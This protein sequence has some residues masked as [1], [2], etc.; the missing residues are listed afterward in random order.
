MEWWY[1]LSEQFPEKQLALWSIIDQNSC[2]HPTKKRTL[3]LDK[4]ILLILS[5]KIPKPKLLH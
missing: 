2:H 3:I 1:E 4:P 5:I